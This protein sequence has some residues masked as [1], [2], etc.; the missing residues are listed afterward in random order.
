M[1]ANNNNPGVT[2]I[3]EGNKIMNCWYGIHYEDS[4]DAIIKNNVFKANV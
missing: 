4:N 2:Q 1:A 3:L